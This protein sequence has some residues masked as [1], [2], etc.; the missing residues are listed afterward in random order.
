MSIA[1]QKQY[2]LTVQAAAPTVDAYWTLQE[3]GKLVNRV[4][5]VHSIALVP[6]PNNVMDATPG[7]FGNGLAF[8]ESTAIIPSGFS[9][10]VVAPLGIQT[11]GGW[12]IFGWFKVPHWDTNNWFNTPTLEL[13]GEIIISWDPLGN[14]GFGPNGPANSVQFSTFDNNVNVFQPANF[15]PVVGQ[16]YFFHFFFDGTHVGYSINN[17]APVFD[18]TGVAV[19]GAEPNGQLRVFADWVGVNSGTIDVILDEIGFKLSR[20]LTGPEVTYLYNGGAGRTW[21]L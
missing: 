9:T 15:V 20:M 12:S 1:C 8:P 7:L 18:L 16:W 5:N 2:T 11:A 19:F 21:P 10:A 13:N 4:D 14:G 3:S 6:N 17:G